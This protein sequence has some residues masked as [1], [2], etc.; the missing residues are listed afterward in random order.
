MSKGRRVSIAIAVLALSIAAYVL[1]PRFA[2]FRVTD[3]VFL[4]VRVLEREDMSRLALA[5]MMRNMSPWPIQFQVTGMQ[6]FLQ[7]AGDIAVEVPVSGDPLPAQ[8]TL[9]PFAEVSGK[10]WI[11]LPSRQPTIG[12]YRIETRIFGASRIFSHD[13]RGFEMGR[14]LVLS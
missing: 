6:A 9:V 12:I 13:W 1:T 4:D 8:F 5:L 11:S 3:L 7:H 2:G 10:C 14:I